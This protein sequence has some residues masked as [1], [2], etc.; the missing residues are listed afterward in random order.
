MQLAKNQTLVDNQYLKSFVEMGLTGLSV[1]GWLYWRF[2]KAALRAVDNQQSR[3]SQIIGLWGIA[4]LSAF[5]VQAFFID[6]WDIF[7]TNAAFW[8]VAA[9]VSVSAQKKALL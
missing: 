7:P 3:I 1:Y 8:I 9:F 4:F 5:I 2:L 6:I